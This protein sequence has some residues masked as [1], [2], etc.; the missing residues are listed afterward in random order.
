[1]RRSAE[2]NRHLVLW[3]HVVGIALAFLGCSAGRSGDNLET[4]F[5]ALTVDPNAIYTI[6]GVASGE[7]VQI[8]G[9]SLANSARAQ[10]SMCSASA[11]QQF[12]FSQ[13]AGGYYNIVNAASGKCLD[14]QS[15]STANG[16][17]VIQYTC[18]GGTNQQWSVTTNTNGSVRL[19][20]RHSGKVM[21]ANQG[22]SADGTYSCPVG[23]VGRSLSA[24]PASNCRN[25]RRRRQRR[26]DELRW[27]N[28]RG[29]NN[30]RGWHD[31]RGRDHCRRRNHGLRR[32]AGCR[33]YAG[34]RPYA[35]RRRYGGRRRHHCYR[36]QRWGHHQW[37]R[38]VIGRH[39]HRRNF[40]WRGR[41]NVIG[42][43]CSSGSNRSRHCR[44]SGAAQCGRHRSVRLGS[45]RP[46]WK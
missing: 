8:A 39:V 23:L 33:Q 42:W 10:L 44:P 37:W 34:C 5:H 7:C 13:V 20:A 27:S 11:S 16:A 6:A 43:K 3:C 32:Y 45:E 24:V 12:R 22:G 4:S 40:D 1:M 15:K 9:L 35:R 18:N 30:R 41:L 36:G 31:E 38:D 25:R 28:R 26:S 14:V 19:T 29:W 17:A 46:G 2:F 21:E